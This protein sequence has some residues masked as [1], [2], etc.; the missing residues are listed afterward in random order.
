[1]QASLWNPALPSPPHSASSRSSSSTLADDV[2]S[3]LAADQLKHV[4]AL[5]VS[6]AVVD[7]IVDRVSDAVDFGLGLSATTSSSSAKPSSR[8]NHT[9]RWQSAKDQD[10]A[11]STFTEFVST[12]LR[13]AEVTMSGVLGALVYI[14]RARPYLS[15][16]IEEW[17][18][19]R[20]I[21][22]A[23]I[24]ASKY[25]NDASLKNAH[26]ALCTGVF[27]RRDVARIEREFLEVLDFEL[28]VKEKDIVRECSRM[29]CEGVFELPKSVQEKKEMSLQAVRAIWDEKSRLE[30]KARPEKRHSDMDVDVDVAERRERR[31]KERRRMEVYLPSTRMHVPSP[32]SL[33]SS[34]SPAS[35]CSTCASSSPGSSSSSSSDADGNGSPYTPPPHN[36]AFQFL[37][38][39]AAAVALSKQYSNSSASY[40][41]LQLL[42]HFPAVPTP[43][44]MLAPSRSSMAMAPPLLP[45]YPAL[46]LNFPVSRPPSVS[47]SQPVSCSA[48]PYA[49]LPVPVAASSRPASPYTHKRSTAMSLY[50]TYLSAATA[51]H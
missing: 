38:P 16:A 40:K 3:A 11:R 39:G 32:D 17:A 35:S 20:V 22:G 27:G 10:T 2:D 37:Y 15:I 21:L 1:M 42:E 14:D 43:P 30:A 28:S 9:R 49:Q 50:P 51:S 29:V 13:R 41:P 25:L 6:P 34:V 12:V 31:R 44:S 26:W 36:P 48:S 47:M 45:P 46:S 33:H 18:H 8:R 19:H 23:L 24:L 4:V 7:Y 5:P